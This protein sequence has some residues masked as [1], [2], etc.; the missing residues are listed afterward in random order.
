MYS[1][2]DEHGREL[3]ASHPNP[4]DVGRAMTSNAFNELVEAAIERGNH[5]HVQHKKKAPEQEQ[6]RRW[7]RNRR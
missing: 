2:Y 4:V 7:T 6:E 3:P 5:P 1:N